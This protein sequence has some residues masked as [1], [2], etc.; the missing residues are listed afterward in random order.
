MK[1][2][3]WEKVLFLFLTAPLRS[4]APRSQNAGGRREG[5]LG[6][7]E[8]AVPLAPVVL[9]AVLDSPVALMIFADTFP[10]NRLASDSVKAES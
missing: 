10:P 2:S 9:V 7:G 4:V 6:P 1:C 8:R 3:F 5:S